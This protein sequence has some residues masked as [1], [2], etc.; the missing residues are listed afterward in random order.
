MLVNHAPQIQDNPKYK[1]WMYV[2]RSS[3]YLLVPLSRKVYIIGQLHNRLF[4]I[5]ASKCPRTLAQ[6]QH[7]MSHYLIPVALSGQ[8]ILTLSLNTVKGT[9]QQSESFTTLRARE[10]KKDMS[11]SERARVAGNYS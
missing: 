10:R 9:K 3:L 4:M 8:S 11:E 5:L 2:A 6:G 7:T 1:D